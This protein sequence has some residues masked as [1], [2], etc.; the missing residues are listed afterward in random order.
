MAPDIVGELLDGR[1]APRGILLEGLQ[2]DQ[3]QVA[4]QSASDGCIRRGGAGAGDLLLSDG[5][6][7]IQQ[8]GILEAVRLPAGQ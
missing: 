4:P 7:H 3:I 2:K 5:A 8:R 1:V 6:L